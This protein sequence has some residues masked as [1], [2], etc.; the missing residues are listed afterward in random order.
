[1][2]EQLLDINRNAHKQTLHPMSLPWP[3]AIS[4]DERRYCS[5][6]V[7]GDDTHGGEALIY[8]AKELAQLSE[9]EKHVS[10]VMAL[11][12]TE[13]GGFEHEI[14][15]GYALHNALSCFA[16]EE[17]QHADMFYR[18]VRLLLGRDFKLADNRMAARLALYQGDDS[19]LVK[20]GALVA[21]AYVGESVMTVF[22]H[23]IDRMDPTARFFVS[24]VVKLHGL[25]EARHI[26]FD[27]FIFEHVIA[28]YTPAETR[29]FGQILQGQLE[30]NRAL[31]LDFEELARATTG[32]DYLTGNLAHATQ[33]RLFE[34]FAKLV[35]AG[36]RARRID[37]VLDDSVHGVLSEFAGIAQIHPAA[38]PA[39][40]AASPQ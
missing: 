31:G 18:Y 4:D 10:A 40:A 24:Q 32:R 11:V 3:A 35:F 33:Q 7:F 12:L 17:L 23:R 20:L 6:F 2:Y 13:L 19:V 28:R 26:Q 15:A 9:I 29:R 38:R 27:H 16:A 8:V 14:A 5:Q 39:A 25:D 21:G 22:E 34:V 1:M 30:L 37:D 36:G